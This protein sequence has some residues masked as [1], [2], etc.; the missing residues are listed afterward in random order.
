MQPVASGCFGAP[1]LLQEGR[2]ASG[3]VPWRSPRVPAQNG[4]GHGARCA[5]KDRF[6]LMYRSVAWIASVL[7]R[8]FAPR[9]RRLI[10]YISADGYRV[11]EERFAST[12]EL[13]A[14]L[15]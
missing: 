14:T 3:P 6:V 1:D 5:P 10:I 9:P 11:G 13:L 12:S 8:G 4:A 15:L 7:L 2:A